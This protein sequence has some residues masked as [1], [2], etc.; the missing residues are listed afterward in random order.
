MSSSFS[1]V[2]AP[3]KFASSTTC[4]LNTSSACTSFSAGLFSSSISTPEARSKNFAGSSIVRDVSLVDPP[5]LETTSRTSNVGWNCDPFLNGWSMFLFE[6]CLLPPLESDAPMTTKSTTV[7][8]VLLVVFFFFF[9]ISNYEFY[10][11][12]E[13][14]L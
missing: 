11:T 2:G 5:F 8:K 10:L 3:I 9:A 4:L 12:N 7:R 1:V 14:G 13:L 6:R